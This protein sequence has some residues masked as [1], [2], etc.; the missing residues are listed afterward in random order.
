MKLSPF[1]A[2]WAALLCL[3]PVTEPAAY[4]QEAPS[5][6]AAVVKGEA[7]LTLNRQYEAELRAKVE[8]P[9]NAS[10]QRL[11]AS[12]AAAVEAAFKKASAQG[13]LD[14]AVPLQNEKKAFAQSGTV[15]EKDEDGTRPELAKLRNSYRAEAA[16][17]ARQRVVSAQP[18]LEAH[19]GRLRVLEKELTKTEKLDEALE[20]RAQI[21]AL[22]Q[23]PT[24]PA[25]T[26]IPPVANATPGGLPKPPVKA[27]ATPMLSAVDAS[28]NPVGTW[29]FKVNGGPSYKR[30]FHA[31][32]T[33]TGEGFPGA[34]KWRV[35]GNKIIIS[36]PQGEGSMSLPL[37][38]AGTKAYGHT[39]Q[40]QLATKVQP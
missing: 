25:A 17:L 28:K 29:I 36:Y 8:E 5:V 11:D 32:R 38:P 20:V 6:P 39:G 18:I 3:S 7:L 35:S 37:N 14:D 15:P 30:T 10:K 21:V 40:E 31:D 34:G 4:A 23:Q 1:N 22:A 16:R 19:L 27:G 9:L 13:Q 2:I 12:Y 24:A 26:A 33:I